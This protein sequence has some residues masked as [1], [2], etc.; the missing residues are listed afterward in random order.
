VVYFQLSSDAPRHRHHLN[1][2]VGGVPEF[3]FYSR[4]SAKA[5]WTPDLANFQPRIDVVGVGCP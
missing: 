2:G 3:P 1:G 5:A 4:T